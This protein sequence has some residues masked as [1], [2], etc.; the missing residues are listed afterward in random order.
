MNTRL[1]R[2]WMNDALC[3]QTDPDLFFPD[4]DAPTDR[5]RAAEQVCAECPVQQRCAA[6]ASGTGQRHG[7]WGG[8]WLDGPL[9]P[10]GDPVRLSELLIHHAPQPPAPAKEAA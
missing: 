6:Y 2:D 3:A 7:I 10:S 5:V 1:G 4:R 8:R 9:P